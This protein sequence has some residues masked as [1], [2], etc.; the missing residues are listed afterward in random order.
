[1]DENKLNKF[2][3]KGYFPLE[4]AVSSATAMLNDIYKHDPESFV[5]ELSAS[6]DEVPHWHI[7]IDCRSLD[8]DGRYWTH[9]QQ[10]DEE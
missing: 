5:M 8:G 1:M 7:E 2:R 6:V 3:P 4:H 9:I 10:G